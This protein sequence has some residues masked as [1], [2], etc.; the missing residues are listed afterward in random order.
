MRSDFIFRVHNHVSA[1]WKWSL[2]FLKR[3]WKLSDYPIAVREHQIDPAYA[4]TRL[5]QHRYSAATVNW[6]VMSGGGDTK[7]QALEELEK[8]FAA[9]K[10]ERSK[11]GKPLPRPGTPVQIE[12][13]S[14]QRVN[15]HPELTEDF[16]RRVLNVEEA[17]ISDDSS[18][19]DFHFSEDNR[20]LITK[21][22]EVYEVDVSD[23]ESANLSEILERI[24]SNRKGVR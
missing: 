4:G 13:A 23:I 18:L 15:A 2:S 12:F 14:Q 1:A 7:R 22:K 19:W 9:Q 16:I 6:W 3:D 10:I 5:K 21:V 20:A 8:H 24:A 11:A 17:W